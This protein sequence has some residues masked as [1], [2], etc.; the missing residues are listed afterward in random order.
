M[1]WNIREH[2]KTAV[3]AGCG[4]LGSS[5]ACL[6]ES[7]GYDVIVIDV[8][9]NAFQRLEENFGGFQIQ[10][11]ASDWTVLER[12]SIQECTLLLA[13]TNDDNINC[14][15]ALIGSVIY[16][17]DQVY[18][19]LQDPSRECLL[20]ATNIKAI[21]PAR[22]SLQEFEKISHIKMKGSSVV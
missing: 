11:D 5:L 20:D 16:H 4:R 17:I 22:L 15:I 12:S 6:L 1:M 2:K 9:P 8:N 3:I 19:R 10:G 7:E 18:T 14:M 13:V 21:Y